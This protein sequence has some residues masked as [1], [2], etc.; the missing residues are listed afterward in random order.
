MIDSL[1][2]V[3]DTSLGFTHPGFLTLET[4][5]AKLNHIAQTWEKLL[6][7]SGGALNLLK[8][9]WYTMYWDWEKGRPTL[10]PIDSADP[11]LHLNTQGET[12]DPTPIKRIP[13]NKA[14]QILGVYLAPDGNFSEHSKPRL[15]ILPFASVHP[16][17]TKR[18][19][20]LPSDNVCPLDEIRSPVFGNL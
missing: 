4:I 14:S 19:K 18:H 3:D 2:I 20:N 6:F 16:N 10:R 15:I 17:N 7:Y 5:I 8:C 11:H 13:L 1:T 9:S 12:N